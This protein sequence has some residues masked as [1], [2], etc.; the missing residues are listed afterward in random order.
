[1]KM[2]KYKTCLNSVLYFVSNSHPNMNFIHIN[3]S[4][5]YERKILLIKNKII[6][7]FYNLSFLH[8]VSGI[9]ESV[10]Y[11]IIVGFVCFFLHLIFFTLL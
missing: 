9:A 1:M 5:S 7:H 8:F 11:M 2:R 6:D 4:M 10:L 3:R